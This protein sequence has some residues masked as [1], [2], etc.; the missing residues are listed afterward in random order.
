MDVWLTKKLGNLTCTCHLHVNEDGSCSQEGPDKF[1]LHVY[2]LRHMF[3]LLMTWDKLLYYSRLAHDGNYMAIWSHASLVRPLSFIFLQ[4]GKENRQPPLCL[5]CL[6]WKTWLADSAFLLF[7]SRTWHVCV[8]SW[9]KAQAISGIK[10]DCF[11]QTRSLNML[12]KPTV[13]T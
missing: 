12:L 4:Y 11:F 10:P 2:A 13:Y 9:W 8:T 3:K 1:D 7:C 6:C 5:T